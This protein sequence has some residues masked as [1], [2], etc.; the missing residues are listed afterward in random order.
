M[1]GRRISLSLPEELFE[2]VEEYRRREGCTRSEVLA[3]A[4]REHLGLES[5]ALP[6]SHRAILAER[7]AAARER[8][9]EGSSWDDVEARLWPDLTS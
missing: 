6:E 3:A 2:S 7:L 4:L 9:G 5:A 8:P 1:P